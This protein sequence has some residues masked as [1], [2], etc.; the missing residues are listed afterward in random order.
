MLLSLRCT[1]VALALVLSPAIAAAEPAAQGAPQGIACS[2]PFA[3]DTSHAKLLTAFGAAN[4]T[5]QQIEGAEG[6]TEQATVLFANDPTRR[7]EVIWGNAKARAKPASVMIKSPSTWTGP[8]GIHT[9]MAIADVAQHNGQ[10][11][12]INGFEWDYGGYA[13]SLKGKLASLPGGCGV[14]LRF[15]PGV[16]LSGKTFRSI[17]GDKQVR[18]DNAVLLSARPALAEWS[19][20]YD[21]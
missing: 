4:V 11:F 8:E 12:K 21:D 14:T 20:V 5:D 18:S 9:G 16:E 6:S 17:I 2:G 13:V 15:S 19:M 10:P 3:K 1:L 7:I